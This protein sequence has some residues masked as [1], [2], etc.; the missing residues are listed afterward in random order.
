MNILDH[1]YVIANTFNICVVFLARSQS[2][3]V[4]PLVSD[5]DGPSRTIFVGL[6]EELQH[7]IQL[8]DGCP[9][10]PLHVQWEYHRVMRVSGWAAPYRDRMADWVTRYS[11]MYPPQR[12][13]N[14][15]LV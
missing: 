13:F 9:L 12:H 15:S 7:F 6:I 11:E 3:T 8:V 2:T 5:M 10:P 1:L 4:L 14:V